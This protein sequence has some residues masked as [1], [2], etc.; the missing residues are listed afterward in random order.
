MEKVEKIEKWVQ[1][2]AALL[3]IGFSLF[4]LVRTIINNPV[5]FYILCFA[6]M[7]VVSWRL[8]KITWRELK[9]FEKALK[10]SEEGGVK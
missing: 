7:T 6:A 4:N 8:F 5:V 2:G 10:E 1:V 3:I 9:E